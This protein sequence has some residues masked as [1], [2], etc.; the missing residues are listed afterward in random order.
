M[1]GVRNPRFLNWL[2]VAPILV[3]APSA[4]H[5][6]PAYPSTSPNGSCV[7]CHVNPSGGL[8]LDPFGLAVKAYK[9]SHADTAWWPT[10]YNLD[11]DEDGF[12]NGEEL[13][14]PCGTWVPGG[15]P[16]F[17]SGITEPGVAESV[18]TQHTVG[19]CPVPGSSS[20]E[21]GSSSAMGSSHGPDPSSS[22]MSGSGIQE[23][24]SSAVMGS[25]S[26]TVAPS[27]LVASFASL[28]SS[29]NAT[30]G[31]STSTTVV[32]STSARASSAW[33][34]SSAGPDVD[35]GDD[36]DDDS[37]GCSAVVIPDD[38]GLPAG[39]AL[40]LGTLGIAFRRRQR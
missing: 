1:K 15:T 6:R 18:P 16:Q 34:A 26:A 17:T 30:S 12:T 11:I 3:V 35:T 32:S 40:V 8:P 36:D 22:A 19:V 13:G 10:L 7:A 38:A 27:S 28:A 14:D 5:A 29:G 33:I 25:S 31:V 37:A 23:S 4:S 9:D 24:S 21:M 39:M 20:G 2:L